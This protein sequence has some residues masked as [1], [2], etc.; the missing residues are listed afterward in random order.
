VTDYQLS[1]AQTGLD[2]VAAVRRRLG[3]TV[4]AILVTGDTSPAVG[5]VKLAE[6]EMMR[7]PIDTNTLL[8]VAQSMIARSRP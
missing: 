7:K 3:R 4:P 2:V 6:L 5:D 1:H 8:S